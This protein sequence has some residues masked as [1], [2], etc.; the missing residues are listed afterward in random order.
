MKWRNFFSMNNTCLLSFSAVF[1]L[2]CPAVFWIDSHSP[3]SSLARNLLSPQKVQRW[4]TGKLGTPLWWHCA[5]RKENVQLCKSLK[6][7]WLLESR[8]KKV[9]FLWNGRPQQ[10]SFCKGYVWHLHPFKHLSPHIV[11]WRHSQGFFFF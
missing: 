3:F 7:S 10:A 11:T 6:Y 1:S 8:M 4:W 5:F 2:I 9:N